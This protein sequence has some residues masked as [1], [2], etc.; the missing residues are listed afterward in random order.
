M[1]FWLALKIVMLTS[2]SLLLSQI[3]GKKFHTCRPLIKL[4][5]DTDKFLYKITYSSTDSKDLELKFGSGMRN[6]C[7]HV[8]FDEKV[9]FF[10]RFSE[11]PW[12]GT[13]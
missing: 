1:K 6:R 12:S 5:Y 13:T 10:F 4:L 9:T 8:P 3:I 7:D 2:S 11:L